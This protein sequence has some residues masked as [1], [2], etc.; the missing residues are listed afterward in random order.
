MDTVSALD[1]D[2]SA[3]A[4]AAVAGR[5]AAVL[6]RPAVCA[7][8]AGASTTGGV[9]ALPIPKSVLNFAGP[10]AMPAKALSLLSSGHRVLATLGGLP[11]D[12]RAEFDNGAKELTLGLARLA[13]GVRQEVFVNDGPGAVSWEDAR[14]Q[15][16]HPGPEF[17]MAK[18][19]VE[20]LREAKARGEAVT[21]SDIARDVAAVGKDDGIFHSALHIAES[22]GYIERSITHHWHLT[23]LG[24]PVLKNAPHVEALEGRIVD[25][26]EDTGIA[27]TGELALAVGA[28]DPSAPEFLAALER[29]LADGRVSWLN[30]STYGLPPDQLSDFRRGTREELRA[31]DAPI[32]VKKEAAH[33]ASLTLELRRQ[34]AT[35]RPSATLGRRRKVAA[36]DD[37][38]SRLKQLAELHAAG[39]IDDAEFSAKKAEILEL[40]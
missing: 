24:D 28:R 29:A 4:G 25:H 26:I 15:G 33:V 35:R 3:S 9:R 13:R 19:I 38:A 5:E 23:G 14:D 18:R 12:Q 22:D 39:V 2:C 34:L 27:D 40:F 7:R 21:T 20:C 36:H 16:L 1:A 10:V 37:P 8:M 31:R 30:W 11:A 32:D 6:K 17:D